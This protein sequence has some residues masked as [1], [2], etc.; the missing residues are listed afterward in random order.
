MTNNDSMNEPMLAINRKLGY[1][2]EPGI[3]ALV[4]VINIAS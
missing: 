3:Y 2:S 1:Q 4:K